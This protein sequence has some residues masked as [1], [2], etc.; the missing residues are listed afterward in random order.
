MLL[1]HGQTE[2]S[3]TGRHTS[4]TEVELTSHG[5]DEARALAP[6]LAGRR[7][8]AVLCSP[9]LRARR[10]A[11]LAGLTVTAVDD[12]LAEWDY[13]SY[14]GITTAE[15]RLTRP[16]WS[17]WTDGAPDGETPDQVAVRVDRVLVGLRE[18]LDRGDVAIVGHGHSLRVL[19]ARWVGLPAGGGA[20]LKLDTGTLSVLGLEHERHVIAQWNSPF[21]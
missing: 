14:E 12:D 10:T 4:R 8:E 16:D 20:L 19:G 7:F 9:R 18:S 21:A 11:E 1:R 15:I 13:G 6:A 5:E 17:L 3:A 2:W